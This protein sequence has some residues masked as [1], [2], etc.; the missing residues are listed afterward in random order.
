M[1]RNEIY[2]ICDEQKLIFEYFAMQ[3]LG[4]QSKPDELM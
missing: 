4:T 2:K 1:K 3:L